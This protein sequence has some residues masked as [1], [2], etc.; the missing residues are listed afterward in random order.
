MFFIIVQ[1][2]SGEKTKMFKRVLK[3]FSIKEWVI[4][5]SSITLTVTA[6][7]LFDRQNYLTLIASLIGVTSLIICSKGN[8]LGQVF[9]IAFSLL[10]GIISYFCR[11]FGEM[12]TYV[13]MSMPMA[14]F[15]LVSWLKNPYEKNKAEVKVNKITRKE[16]VFLLFLTLAVTVVFYFILKWFNTANLWVSTLSVATSFL[17][18]Y[19]TF[20]RSPFFAFAYALNDIVLIVMWVYMSII[21]IE[22]VSVAVCF[23]A[24]LVNDT[25]CFVSWLK[26]QK[27]QNNDD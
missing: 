7:I 27:R 9:M 1:S 21:S 18:S 16:T 24:F 3:Y 4:W 11:Y 13:F 14:I 22:Y 23:L 15:S 26:M 2:T 25:Y 10:Y 17:A 12:I 20:R 19:L 5:L 8:P 6:F